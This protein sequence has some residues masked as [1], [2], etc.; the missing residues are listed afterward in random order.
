MKINCLCGALIEVID[1]AVYLDG[2]LYA[3]KDTPN[4]E[5]YAHWLKADVDS[6]ITGIEAGPRPFRQFRGKKGWGK[7]TAEIEL[8]KLKRKYKDYTFV[9]KD[10]FTGLYS[11]RDHYII[12]IYEPSLMRL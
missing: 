9:I 8:E 10:E 5:Q 4:A 1:N 6:E 11:E 3:A 2:M 12:G 7:R